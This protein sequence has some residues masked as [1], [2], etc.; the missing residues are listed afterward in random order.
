MQKSIFIIALLLTSFTFYGQEIDSLKIKNIKTDKHQKTLLNSGIKNAN[1][2]LYI[3]DGIE[4]PYERLKKINP[5]AI[6][7]LTVLKDKKATDKYGEKGKNGVIVIN[8]K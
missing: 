7:S 8:L 5:K 3:V 2:V 1:E 4:Y 6:S